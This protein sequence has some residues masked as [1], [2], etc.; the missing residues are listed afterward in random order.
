MGIDHIE[1]EDGDRD[2]L[3]LVHRDFLCLGYGQRADGPGGS[4]PANLRMRTATSLGAS[5]GDRWPMPGSRRNSACG[6]RGKSSCFSTAGGSTRS[7]VPEMTR[8]GTSIRET[9]FAMSS[10]LVASGHRSEERR[11]GKEFR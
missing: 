4:E 9:R 1:R 10:W 8:V 2:D 7:S 6:M 11:V 3:S 5:R